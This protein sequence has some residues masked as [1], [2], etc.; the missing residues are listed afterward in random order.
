M[1]REAQTPEE[2]FIKELAKQLSE[3]KNSEV[4]ITTFKRKL[5]AVSRAKNEDKQKNLAVLKRI[6]KM[7]PIKNFA[8]FSNRCYLS[9][10]IEQD[11][12]N[13]YQP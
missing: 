4:F 5:I 6:L 9:S 8:H 1:A 13:F 12:K 7:G 11:L 2:N 10:L 3:C